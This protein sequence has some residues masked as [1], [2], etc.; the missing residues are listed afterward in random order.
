MFIWEQAETF[1]I[2]QSLWNLNGSTYTLL[3]HNACHF[4][5]AS[6]EWN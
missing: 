6:T 4:T 1:N 2:P 3:E 5:S